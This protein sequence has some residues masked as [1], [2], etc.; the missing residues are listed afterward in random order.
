VPEV[1]R[2]VRLALHF[3]S[4]ENDGFKP[5][6]DLSRATRFAD[7]NGDAQEHAVRHPDRDRRPAW[8][9]GGD[10]QIRGFAFVEIDLPDA[11]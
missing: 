9:P 7:Q 2:D 8:A 11:T 3:V 5:Q 4:S 1:R 6:R 10:G